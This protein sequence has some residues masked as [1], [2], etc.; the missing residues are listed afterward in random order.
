MEDPRERLTTGVSTAELER[1]WRAIRE[2]MRDNKIDFLVMQNSEDFLGGYMRWFTDFPAEYQFPYTVIFPADDEMTTITCGGDPPSPQFPPEW[3]ARGI[4]NRLGAP[5]FSSIPYTNTYDAEL[6]VGVLKERK[7][8]TIGLVGRAFIPITFYEH[9]TKHL[10]DARF[11][12]ATDQV[13]EIK[14]PKSPEEIEL[15]KRTAELQDMAIEYVKRNIRPGMK[16][17]EVFAQAQFSTVTS[18]SERQLILCSSG[19]QGTPVP[20][21]YRRFQNRVI[22]E[23]DHVY[24][25]LETNG[26]GGYYTEIS[27]IFSVGMKP[28][29]ELQDAV[30]VAA[31][32]QELTAELLKPGADP[33]DVWDETNSFLKKGGYAPIARLY[34]HGQGYDL[35]ERPLIRYNETWKLKAGMNIAVHP[36]AANEKVRIMICD[37]YL[38]TETGPATCL[39]KYPKGVIVV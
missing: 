26:P 17:Y 36:F 32:A 3:A 20:P 38:I 29:Q 7:G 10:P 39:H 6:A 12:D 14:V 30:G 18:G 24:L 23:G 1:R 22:K 9:L 5:Y 33:K 8:A 34:A 4:K 25:L 2:M 21:G 11:V 27:R 13:D 16:D 28:S 15:I 19:P 35:V 31:E 37:N